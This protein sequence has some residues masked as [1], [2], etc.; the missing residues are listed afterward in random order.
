MTSYRLGLDVGTNSLGWSILE[1]SE[2]DGNMLPCRVFE[3]RRSHFFPMAGM[4]N[5]RLR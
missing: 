1:L 2:Q 4:L 5:P 3:W